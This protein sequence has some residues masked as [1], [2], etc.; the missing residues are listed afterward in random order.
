[1]IFN[2]RV[3]GGKDEREREIFAHI[4]KCEGKNVVV[5]DAF[6]SERNEQKKSSVKSIFI[7]HRNEASQ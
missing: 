3:K 4:F 6:M 2:E 5:V 7:K 1:M